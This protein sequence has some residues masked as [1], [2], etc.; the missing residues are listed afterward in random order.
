MSQCRLSDATIWL[1][2]YGRFVLSG[3]FPLGGGRRVWNTGF[4]VKYGRS[5]NPTTTITTYAISIM[6]DS[7]HV[8]WCCCVVFR[9]LKKLS[10]DMSDLQNTK[11]L[12]EAKL[13]VTKWAALS[14]FLGVSTLYSS[15]S[16]ILLVLEMACLKCL[17]ISV[18]YIR[19]IW[20]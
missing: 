7:I 11:D 17:L 9:K 5:G 14:L 19:R 15:A 12:L 6:S 1:T 18:N 20:L 4:P 8:C 2:E 10:A 3:G 13:E 16:T